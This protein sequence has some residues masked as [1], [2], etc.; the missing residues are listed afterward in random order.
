MAFARGEQPDDLFG[1]AE[2]QKRVKAMRE[3]IDEVSQALNTLGKPGPWSPDIKATDDFLDPLFR[4]FFRKLAL[5][6]TFR[7]ADYHE[8]ANLVPRNTIEPEIG[9]KLDVIVELANKGKP[10][11]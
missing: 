11:T 7:K 9:E 4:T 5:P 2:Q 6:L 1:H 3:A 10:R 8:L